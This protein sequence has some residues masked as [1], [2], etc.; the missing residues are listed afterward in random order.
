M[1]PDG[2]GISNSLHLNEVKTKNVIFSLKRNMPDL[3]PPTV[4]F[5]GVHLDPSLSWD[6][7][8]DTL[9]NKLARSIFVIRNLT[10]FLPL[11]VV[12]I[13]YHALFVSNCSYALLSW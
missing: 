12:L 7:H 2:V 6:K 11:H 9:A 10:E 4:K 8:T 5:L 13:A 1:F 3:N